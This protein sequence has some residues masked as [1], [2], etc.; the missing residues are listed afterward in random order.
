MAS[1]V[2]VF[3][4]TIP[5]AGEIP[6]RIAEVT[7]YSLFKGTSLTGGLINETMQGMTNKVTDA[8]Q[9]A[10]DYYVLGLP[11]GKMLGL[12][13]VPKS[14]IESIIEA[15]I[16]SS[17]TVEYSFIDL[18][19]AKVAVLPY[20]MDVRGYSV[21]SNAITEHTFAPLTP[22][23]NGGVY[24]VMLLDVSILSGTLQALIRYYHPFWKLD[25]DA[26]GIMVE[27]TELFQEIIDTDPSMIVGSSYCIAYYY[28]LN[29]GQPTGDGVF[30]FYR[31]ASG[32]YP[33]LDQTGVG[34]NDDTYLPI[35]PLRR[36]NVDL[37]ATK[38][39]LYTTSKTLLH[40]LNI[41]IDELADNLNSNPD[42]ADI[43]HAYVMFGVDINTT[44]VSC[45]RYLNEYFTYLGEIQQYSSTDYLSP[46]INTSLP[47]Q[48]T[49]TTH[50]LG[51]NLSMNATILE[52]GLKMELAWDYI[53]VA[54]KVG[55]IGKIGHATSEM[56]IGNKTIPAGQSWEALDE[57]YANAEDSH[58]ILRL[59]VSSTQYRETTVHNLIHKNYV[60]KK[61]TVATS[62]ADSLEE[63]NHNLLIP[64]H[65]G[66]AKRLPK[67]KRND[68]F[69]ASIVLVIN[70]YVKT[71]VKWY[72]TKIF[73]LFVIIV[74][75]VITIY[76][77]NYYLI[78]L[79]ATLQQG[80]MALLL[81]LAWDVL[82]AYGVSFAFKYVVREIGGELGII[83][84]I[85]IAVVAVYRMA[86]LPGLARMSI[87]TAQIM[88]NAGMALIDAANDFFIQA[89][90]AVQRDYEAFEKES[91]DQIK[92]LEAAQDLLK[93]DDPDFDP[94]VFVG[95][96]NKRLFSPE[97]PDAFYNRTIHTGNIGTKVLDVIENYCDIMLK[98]PEPEYN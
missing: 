18:L 62:L 28:V 89:M 16:G 20:L 36:D 37:T 7:L 11:E 73:K 57:A 2:S 4:V 55:T 50:P 21:K 85:V 48:N 52:Y 33:Q 94:L 46:L 91:E 43:D 93:M 56:V 35:V 44:N 14:T 68:L 15:E 58:I 65:F 77:G 29:G 92:E 41:D 75:I 71:K 53:T 66:I 72:Q 6:N 61:H 3:A 23:D 84:G 59:Q 10:K 42:I 19:S 67:L 22:S 8:Y 51:A 64:V 82:L 88:L 40:K 90:K 39:E 83:L 80:I 76:T 26:G 97:S 95:K 9:Y 79:T 1:V 24:P 45:L 27:N 25:M 63:D 17:V 81:T 74:A 86:G 96:Q 69:T 34:F 47:P 13:Q 30:W 32:T 38:D 49:I 31:M 78:N 70:S 12:E 87:P 5:L 60:Y 98:L 54:T